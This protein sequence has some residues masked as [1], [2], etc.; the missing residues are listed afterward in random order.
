M[1]RYNLED[2]SAFVEGSCACGRTFRRLAKIKGRTNEMVKIRGVS[3]YPAA[4]EDVL[5]KF[6][7]LTHEYL[8]V[9]ERAG[10]QERAVL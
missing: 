1:I 3:L 6:P 5:K 2:V 8:L 9:V 10:N 4:L 7:E